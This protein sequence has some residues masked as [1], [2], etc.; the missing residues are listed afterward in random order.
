[1]KNLALIGCGAI[2][3]A[4]MA[5]LR[6]DPALRVA[7]VVVPADALAAA[8]AACAALAPEAR[9]STRLD[10][11][12]PDLLAECAGHG[13]IAE[14]VLPALHLG[15]PAVVASVGAL[16]EGDALTQLAAAAE[17]GGTRVTLISGAI[18]GI[19]ALAAARLGGLDEV[20]YTGRKPAAAWRGTPAEAQWD[21]AALRA[22][23]VLFEGSAR[24]A[25]RLY[26]K[27]A[28]VAA[29]VSLAGL[30]LDATHTVLIADPGITRNQH[31]IEAR[32][33]FGR[34][35][36]TLENEALAA[37][38]KTSALTVYSLVRALHN[39]TGALSL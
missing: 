34:L 19:D 11:P 14:H 17:A 15:I 12:Q 38:P 27:N 37:N 8:R 36:L 33:A 13:A 5:L 24:E 26:P 29:T 23:Q 1:M 20:R 25:A 39:A 31:R 22:P 9:V 32:G 30:G 10:D 3:Q 4:A 2:A 18:G 28:N 16:H 35:D 21:L 7:Q 6:G